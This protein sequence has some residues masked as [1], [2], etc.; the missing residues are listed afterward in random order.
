MSFP[1]W[2]VAGPDRRAHV[3]RV[4]ALLDEWAMAMGVTPAERE[5]WSRAAWLHDALRDAPAVDELAHGPAAA[6]RAWAEGE[7]DA[8][9]LDAVRYHSLGYAGWDDVGK[10]LYLADYLEPGRKFERES[11]A[12]LAA[13]VP[14]ERDEVLREVARARVEWT[15]RSDWPLAAETV[16]FWNALA[17]G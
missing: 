16:G 9:V 5:R 4:A 14:T 2:A 7:R 8:G 11:R 12:A 17:A 1:A 13:R 10:M 3:A 15:V 6:D